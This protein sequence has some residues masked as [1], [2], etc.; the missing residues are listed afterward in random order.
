MVVFFSLS[1]TPFVENDRSKKT[2]RDCD[3]SS[4][5]PEGHF[6]MVSDGRCN[7]FLTMISG[8]PGL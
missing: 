2:V 1:I 5:V 3:A 8:Y 6:S 4:P 7:K